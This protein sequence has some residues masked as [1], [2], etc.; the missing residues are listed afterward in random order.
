MK[1]A[2]PIPVARDEHLRTADGRS[3]GMIL[4]SRNPS[5][6]AHAS[7]TITPGTAFSTSSEFF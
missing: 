5:V 3:A 2:R 7:K 6:A 1:E 4:S